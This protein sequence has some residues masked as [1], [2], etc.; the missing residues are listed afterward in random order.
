ATGLSSNTGANVIATPPTTTTY[1]II[2]TS[3]NGCTSLTTVVATVN[4]K[5]NAAFTTSPDVVDTFNPTIYFNDQ[6]TGGI[7]STWKWTFGDPKNSGSTTKNPSFTYP[8]TS[9]YYPI[10]LVV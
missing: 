7:I 8:D 5:P 6:S 9:A 3:A 1:T 2:G 4:P 10:K